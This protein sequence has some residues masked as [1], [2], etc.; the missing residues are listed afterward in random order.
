[1]NI[2]MQMLAFPYYEKRILYYSCKLHQR[3]GSS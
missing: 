2:E 1:M 3:A